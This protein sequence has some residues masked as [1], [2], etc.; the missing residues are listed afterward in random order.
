MH[1]WCS[2]GSKRNKSFLFLFSS[3]IILKLSSYIINFV[4]ISTPPPLSS[5]S[6]LPGKQSSERRKFRYLDRPEV[7]YNVNFGRGS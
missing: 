7:N 1:G 2:N 5:F 3:L 4:P 6:Y